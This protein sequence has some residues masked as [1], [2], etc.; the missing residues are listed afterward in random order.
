MTLITDDMKTA[1]Y[2]PTVKPAYAGVY[3]TSDKVTG[4]IYFNLFDGQTWYWGTFTRN[5]VR[6]ESAMPAK[7]W[8]LWRGLKAPH[9]GETS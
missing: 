2:P 3:E 5:Y 4:N 8:G 9:D 6:A 7:E 1:W